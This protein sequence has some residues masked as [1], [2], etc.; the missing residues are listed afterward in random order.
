ME[1][2]RAGVTPQSGTVAYAYRRCWPSWTQRV[3]L[4]SQTQRKYASNTLRRQCGVFH[5]GP[6]GPARPRARGDF[7]IGRN[8]NPGLQLAAL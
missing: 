5:W 2:P 4:P 6:R 7:D 8:W 1:S 3:W